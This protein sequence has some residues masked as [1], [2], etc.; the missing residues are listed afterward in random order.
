MPTLILWGERDPLI[1]VAHGR[2]AHELMPDSR[3]E[4][5]EGAGHFPFRDEPDRFVTVLQRFIDETEPATADPARLREM[6]LGE[7][8]A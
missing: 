8:A 4:I 5:F 1:P 6:L 2:A 3:L 7:V